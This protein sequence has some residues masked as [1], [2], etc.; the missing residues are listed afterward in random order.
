M[1]SDSQA[2]DM[3]VGVRFPV[4]KVFP[5]TTRAIWGGSGDSQTISDIDHAFKTLKPRLQST[6]DMAQELAS[7]M[8]PVLERRYGNVLQAPNYTR[9]EPATA[10][11]A[12]GYQKGRGSW[13]V[14]VD[15]NCVSS[16]YGARGFHAVGSGAG[17]A[18]LGGALLAHFRPAEKT[19]EHAKLIA[20]RVIHT[21]IETSAFG[22]GHPIKMWYV[23]EA[24][25]H[26]VSRDDLDVI[27]DSVGA[28][29]QQEEQLLEEILGAKAP[30]PAPL[31]PPVGT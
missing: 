14:E 26:E 22:V 10:A 3:T 21:V 28:W 7:A 4:T 24:G 20:Y 23:D 27:R 5:L 6:R 12:C 31:P 18:L 30:E 25:F 13:I 1:A 15:P 17:F 2:S 19:L 9:A 11:L 8:R 16:H 29:Q